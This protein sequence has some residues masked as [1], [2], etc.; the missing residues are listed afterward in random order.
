MKLE[1]K[2]LKV[3]SF[4]TN[5]SDQS[6]GTREFKGGFTF[7]NTC[8]NSCSGPSAATC[9]SVDLCPTQFEGCSDAPLCQ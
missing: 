4:I 2:A 3:E 6:Q 9:Q 8:W 1:M 5:L 7:I